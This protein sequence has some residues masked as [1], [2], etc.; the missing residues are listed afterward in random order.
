MLIGIKN[1]ASITIP[2]GL[3]TK[4]T[5]AQ[6]V[7]IA[8]HCAPVYERIPTDLLLL[9][10]SDDAKQRGCTA[11]VTIFDNADQAGALGYHDFENDMPDG[12]VFAKTVLD[13]GGTWSQGS[14]SVTTTLSH[15]VLELFVDP[16]ADFWS[17]YPNG[18]TVALECCDPVE[19][20]SYTIGGI[21]MSNFVGSRWFRDGAGPY[22]WTQSLT[23]PFQYTNG[24]YIILRNGGPQFGPGMKKSRRYAKSRTGRMVKRR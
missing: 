24:G 19:D 17:D 13:D 11:L 3:L 12:K 18:D 9:K 7:Q 22:D 1:Q 8:Q 6:R 10:P 14:L 21:A 15:E 23:K 20:E 2:S 4:W 16:Y 5:D